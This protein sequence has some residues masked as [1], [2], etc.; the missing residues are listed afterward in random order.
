LVLLN[1]KQ[2]IRHVYERV[3][4]SKLFAEVI[5]ATDDARIAQAVKDFGGC[6]Q[7]TSPH[8]PSGSDRIA[9]VIADRDCDLVVNVQGDEPLITAEPLA[10]LV[11]TFSDSGVRVA[12]LMT[13]ITDPADLTNPNIV[14]VATSLVGNALYFSR[15]LLPYNRDNAPAVVHYRHIGVY[16]YTRQTLLE[17]VTLPPSPLEQIEKLEQLRL[18]ENGIPI[19][20]VSSAYTGIGIDTPEDLARVMSQISMP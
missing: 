16:A 15:S 3:L 6:C 2:I 20:M 10:A 11:Q 9:E 14:K 19:R 4:D 7:L 17:Y 18:L 5:V 1:G 13:P 12:S 8:H